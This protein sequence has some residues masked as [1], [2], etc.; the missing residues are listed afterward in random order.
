MRLPVWRRWWRWPSTRLD[1][2]C[3]EWTRRAGSHSPAARAR[4]PPR[5]TT[6]LP[7]AI[8]CVY[9]RVS[10]VYV[11][12]DP[13][14]AL[15]SMLS[16]LCYDCCGR[17]RHT[18]TQN[19]SMLRRQAAKRAQLASRT[20]P[21]HSPFIENNAK[22]QLTPMPFVAIVSDACVAFAET[23]SEFY[24]K[25]RQNHNARAPQAIK[26]G[27]AKYAATKHTAFL[28]SVEYSFIFS[29]VSLKFSLSCLI[30]S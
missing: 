22:R 30:R 23:R 2:W 6:T 27:G 3:V 20:P 5:S 11:S 28:I 17:A 16:I 14:L 4:S 7:P 26:T 19:G 9:V 15:P 25:Q 18:A 24:A 13:L 1:D 8:D 12:V 21:Q 10:I 29:G